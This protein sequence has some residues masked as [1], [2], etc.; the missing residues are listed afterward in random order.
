MATMMVPTQDAH[1][2]V[3]EEILGPDL[4]DLQREA[5]ELL[6][7]SLE[8]AD[9]IWELECKYLSQEPT[10]YG[11]SLTPITEHN[12]HDEYDFEELP[13]YEPERDDDVGSDND[14]N[15]NYQLADLRAEAAE[16][17]KRRGEA[18]TL[19]CEEVVA[20]LSPSSPD[21][22]L[23]QRRLQIHK[24]KQRQ[25]HHRQPHR[26]NTADSYSEKTEACMPTMHPEAVSPYY[27]Y[28]DSHLAELYLHSSAS[29]HDE[30]ESD[31][32]DYYAENGVD[33]DRDE[34]DDQD[35]HEFMEAIRQEYLYLAE[36]HLS[37]QAPSASAEGG[38]KPKEMASVEDLPGLFENLME[39]KED[40][41]EDSG[42]DE[43][44]VEDGAS[45]LHHDSGFVDGDDTDS[46]NESF[47]SC[48]DDFDDHVG[49]VKLK[50]D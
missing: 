5:T 43:D 9:L 11:T 40:G 10:G 39:G 13:H 28:D 35:D 18:W 4:L 7:R 45:Y 37:S 34:E 17:D 32:D 38:S 26:I 20:R 42:Y 8:L 48:I 14:D 3:L 44:E 27:E 22:E 1:P 15:I 36:H 33:G 29:P 24:Q 2:N 46:D 50:K 19:F 6:D 30:F 41:D 23:M 21:N 49:I 47:K 25:R 16:L 31:R 12:D